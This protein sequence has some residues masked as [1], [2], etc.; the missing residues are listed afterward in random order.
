M[1][2]VAKISGTVIAEPE[3]SHTTVGEKFYK[4]LIEVAR[5]SGAY[6]EV[7]CIVPEIFAQ[8]IRKGQR[9]HFDGEVRTYYSKDRHL[10]VYI[11]AQKV[12]EEPDMGDYNHIEFDGLIKYPQEPRRTPLTN[13][14]VIDFSIVNRDGNDAVNYIP[15]IAWGRNAYRIANCGAEQKIRITGRFQSRVYEKD[16]TE[17]TVYEISVSGIYML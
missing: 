5:M 6:D 16:G 8:K 11:F 15:A 13:R 1:G 14:T 17:H 9:V 10:E 7:P 2:N 12:Y 4:V 3:Y